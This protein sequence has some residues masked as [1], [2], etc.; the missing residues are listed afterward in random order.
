M[1]LTHHGRH[2]HRGDRQEA[3]ATGRRSIPLTGLKAFVVA[4][5]FDRDIGAPKEINLAARPAAAQAVGAR[6][7]TS[8]LTTLE[9][10]PIRMRADARGRLD[11]GWPADSSAASIATTR[12][13]WRLNL[14]VHLFA[15]RLLQLRA[16]DQ[17]AAHAPGAER[18]LRHQRQGTVLA[19][20]F[21]GGANSLVTEMLG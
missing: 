21:G 15:A 8:A 11:A 19:P 12:G 17:P 18:C 7:T 20:T 16:G 5:A 3:R 14:P 4:N 6:S 9:L 10:N 1:T 2:G 13:G